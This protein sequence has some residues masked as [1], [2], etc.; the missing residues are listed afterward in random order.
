AL[1][2]CFPCS[3]SQSKARSL[4][5]LPS[6]KSLLGK[7]MRLPLRLIPRGA[8]VPILSGPA[9]GVKSTVGSPTHGTWLGIYERTKQQLFQRS[10]RP[11]SVVFDMG[12][13]AGIYSLIGARTGA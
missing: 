4:L 3:T 10:I 1:G 13:H 7:A 12:A 8:V 5:F 2:W 6:S 11:G 9:R